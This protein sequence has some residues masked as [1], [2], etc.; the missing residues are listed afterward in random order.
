M[1][2]LFEKQIQETKNEK[3]ADSDNDNEN[4]PKKK[5]KTDDNQVADQNLAPNKQPEQIICKHIC[6][7]KRR[8]CKF[9]AMRGSE[10]C[11][12]HAAYNKQV[13]IYLYINS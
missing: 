1:D 4:N 8:R 12:E 5:M 7:K 10:F 13:S 9:S 3:L 11:V 2:L 6:E